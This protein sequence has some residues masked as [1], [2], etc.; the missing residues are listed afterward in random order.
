MEAY[1]WVVLI[2][3]FVGSFLL[4]VG[5]LLKLQNAVI[6]NGEAIKHLE[7]NGLKHIKDMHT[8][9]MAARIRAEQE[10]RKKLEEVG[11]AIVV[12]QRNN[13]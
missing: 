3:M 12:L 8:T 10:F 13:K 7:N 4:I 5:A 1:N 9:C 2:A 11:K 6:K